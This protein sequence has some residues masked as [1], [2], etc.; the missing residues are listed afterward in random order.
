[1][2][3]WGLVSGTVGIHSPHV[4]LSSRE[5]VEYFRASV[6]VIPVQILGE[7]VTIRYLDPF[8]NVHR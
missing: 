7:Y 8:G 6:M 4:L 5:L 2:G 3:T 1:M